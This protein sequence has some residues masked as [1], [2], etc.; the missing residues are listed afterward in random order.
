MAGTYPEIRETAMR[1]VQSFIADPEQRTRRKTPNL[2]DL[3]SYLSVIDEVSWPD[4][5]PVFVPE[6]IRRAATRFR[7]PFDPRRCPTGES[8]I[9]R[10]D[11]L[12]PEHG[13]VILFNKV[14][15]DEVARPTHTW[16][17]APGPGALGIA[18]VVTSISCAGVREMY[19]QRWGQL[20]K[21]KRDALLDELRRMRSLGSVSGVLQELIPFKFDLPDVCELILWANKNAGINKAIHAVP[22]LQRMPRVLSTEW[23][24]L[25]MLRSEMEQE[26]RELISRCL[27]PAEGLRAL[28]EKSIQI[29][30]RFRKSGEQPTHRFSSRE[31]ACEVAASARRSAE[32]ARAEKVTAMEAKGGGGKGRLKDGGKGSGKEARDGRTTAGKEK[33]SPSD[34]W[35]MREVRDLITEHPEPFDIDVV[36][37]GADVDQCSGYTLCGARYLKGD[38]EPATGRDLAEWIANKEACDIRR[39]RLVVIGGSR[40]PESDGGGKDTG[41]PLCKSTLL[42]SCALHTA[43]RVEVHQKRRGG[44]KPGRGW[45]KS[46]P[47]KMALTL[48]I[49]GATVRETVFSGARQFYTQVEDRCRLETLLGI[50]QVLGKDVVVLC[51]SANGAAALRHLLLARGGAATDAKSASSSVRLGRHRLTIVAETREDEA[52]ATA[53]G[54]AQ[55]G[56]GMVYMFNRAEN[57]YYALYGAE[58]EAALAPAKVPSRVAGDASNH[59]SLITSSWKVDIPKEACGVTLVVVYDALKEAASLSKVLCYLLKTPGGMAGSTDGQNIVS[60]IVDVFHLV[61]CAQSVLV[62]SEEERRELDLRL[63][64]DG[65]L[66]E[67]LHLHDQRV[68]AGALL[69]APT[70]EGSVLEADDVALSVARALP[71]VLEFKLRVPALGFVVRLRQRF[72]CFVPEVFYGALRS[73]LD[74][75]GAGE[76]TTGAS[77]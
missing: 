46:P 38:G 77:S 55:A 44:I 72:G 39:M 51:G 74:V 54:Q 13:L 4:L 63:A 12:D 8:L 59:G 43:S 2:G 3:V 45:Y 22:D 75:H 61:G 24:R 50:V 10:F 49:V 37:R 65:Q 48:G 30:S 57:R 7:E 19:D 1:D 31:E 66:R 14:F 41:M 64:E 33:Q 18:D 35:A 47:N 62:E 9:A 27:P 20:P 21:C 25:S 67:E 53:E 11:E 73:F 6:M 16:D 26:A 29:E 58:R 70:A 42:A 71:A 34:W 56:G 52:A 28:L 32:A 36:F 15:N 76:A 60:D 40:S 23:Q 68:P 17:T 5:A 69:E